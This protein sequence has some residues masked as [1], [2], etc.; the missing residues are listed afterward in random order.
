MNSDA[1]NARKERAGR[2]ER[3][4]LRLG[5]DDS[6]S[7]PGDESWLD[8]M[9]DDDNGESTEEEG[10][11]TVNDMQNEWEEGSTMHSTSTVTPDTE[12]F[13]HSSE[14][15]DTTAGAEEFSTN[16]WEDSEKFWTSQTPPRPDSV[17]K[18]SDGYQTLVTSPLASPISSNSTP[19][20]I[21]MSK[22]RDYEVTKDSSPTQSPT[23]NHT[24][25]HDRKKR[26]ESIGDDVRCSISDNRHRKRNVLGVS[27]PNVKMQVMSP[28]GHVMNGAPGSLYDSQGFLRY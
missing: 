17:V 11:R 8:E 16:I 12:L 4:Y 24:E 27:T 1:A 22:K 2:G 19:P 10:Q 26:R 5:R 28:T 20:S 23:E 7:M 18:S 3:R 21:K 6:V 14:Q 9:E 13:A 25:D 15:E